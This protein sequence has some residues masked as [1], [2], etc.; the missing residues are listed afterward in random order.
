[1]EPFFI[2]NKINTLSSSKSSDEEK[3]AAIEELVANKEGNLAI[4]AKAISIALNDKS[5][6][7]RNEA[8]KKLLNLL[9]TTN[10]ADNKEFILRPLVDQ[11][12]SSIFNKEYDTL[13]SSIFN[14]LLITINNDFD[15]LDNVYAWLLLEASVIQQVDFGKSKIIHSITNWVDKKEQPK[16]N[17]SKEQLEKFGWERQRDYITSPTT[18]ISTLISALEGF[19][20]KKLEK[21]PIDIAVLHFVPIID[22]FRNTRHSINAVNQALSN[23]QKWTKELVVLTNIE[24]EKSDKELI[25]E[26]GY[27]RNEKFEIS[28][29]MIYKTLVLNYFIPK[30]LINILIDK[31]RICDK[32]VLLDIFSHI[33]E[34]RWQKSTV[35]NVCKYILHPTDI[36]AKS[37]KE[38]NRFYEKA[39]K[40]VIAHLT[41]I[42]ETAYS[43]LNQ[44]QRISLKNITNTDKQL[45]ETIEN[46]I[47][48]KTINIDIRSKSLKEYF[49]KTIPPNLLELIQDKK[50][51]FI[52]E[53][54]LMNG[55]LASLGEL[56]YQNSIGWLQDLWN[57]R[58]T[59]K[60]TEDIQL[61]IIGAIGKIGHSKM[62]GNTDTNN[63][64]SLNLEFMLKVAFDSNEKKSIRQKAKE[65][66]ELS[67]PEEIARVQDWL[68]LV[69]SHQ[70][71]K[72][73]AEQIVE[74]DNNIRK[75]FSDIRTQQMVS[76]TLRYEIDAKLRETDF[77]VVNHKMN[78]F[79]SSIDLAA[80]QNKIDLLMEKAKSFNK[81]ISQ[82][83]SKLNEKVNIIN[84]LTQKQKDL[85]NEGKVL[86]RTI[87]NDR[88]RIEKL[89]RDI[90]KHQ[91]NITANQDEIQKNTSI[92]RSEERK[93][94]QAENDYN[95]ANNQLSSMTVSEDND[96]QIQSLKKEL[97]KAKSNLE[98]AENS[99]RKL[100]SSN[101]GLER[102]INKLQNDIRQAQNEIEDKQRAI[103]TNSRSMEEIRHKS[104]E[105]A[106][107][108]KQADTGREEY[109]QELNRLESELNIIKSQIRVLQDEYKTI[110]KEFERKDKQGRNEIKGHNSDFDSFKSQYSGNINQINE[111]SEYGLNLDNQLETSKNQHEQAVINYRDRQ[112][113]FENQ[114]EKCY[115]VTPQNFEQNMIKSQNIIQELIEQFERYL[116]GYHAIHG[117]VPM[118]KGNMSNHSEEIIRTESEIDKTKDNKISN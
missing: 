42:D 28:D 53:P 66:I 34:L 16:G 43:K 107:K 96:A 36:K 52:A 35:S 73:L 55:V 3:S 76:N 78:L 27:K 72:R 101:S 67:Y 94:N 14:E 110:K 62:L 112:Q 68:N 56:K 60:L 46:L 50:N 77:A 19:S 90:P 108:I 61:N 7:I 89:E 113:D 98:K 29:E 86:M 109:R 114:S 63:D 4:K 91:K 13:N 97:R 10:N 38:I 40:F 83:Q 75:N 59:R 103:M 115:E 39:T 57:E 100:N 41:G 11:V 93:R 24:T 84:E 37:Q 71:A 116:K 87:E 88:K 15:K 21:V 51:D 49:T 99:I 106:N 17:L 65:A 54:N 80:L 20:S 70:K 31:T 30:Y 47:F 33:P 6:Y 104:N 85:E 58:H 102:S 111:L 79:D 105:Q 64:L 95:R 1:M 18:P 118:L 2:T 9:N 5:V 74:I 117:I 45:R 82:T 69:V 32:S 26:W 8:V 22:P 25:E 23:I 92:L 81:I 12:F 48:D 44:G